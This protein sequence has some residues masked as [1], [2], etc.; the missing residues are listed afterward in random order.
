MGYTRLSTARPSR[1][2]DQRHRQ[3]EFGA[4]HVGARQVLDD[5][6]R[7]AAQHG[8]QRVVDAPQQRAGEGVEQDARHH[9]GIQ[10]DNGRHHHAGHRADRRRQTPAQREH[11]T[12]TNADGTA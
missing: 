6:H 9:I 3:L 7:E 5:S 8:A 1:P 10:I 11:P 2:D 12:D 4:D